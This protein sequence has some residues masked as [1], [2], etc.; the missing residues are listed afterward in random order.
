MNTFD[1]PPLE[2]SLTAAL[3]HKINHKTKPLGALGKLESLAVQIGQVQHTLT[4]QLIKPTLLIFAGDHGIA[5][6][7]VSPYPQAVTAQ[8]V[9]NFLQGGAAIN[10]FAKQQHIAL[11]IIDAGVNHCFAAH[12]QLVNA[13]IAMGTANSLHQSAMSLNQCEQALTLGA[14]LAIKEIDAGCNIIGFGEME[15]GR[16]HV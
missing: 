7:G 9:T 15:I 4:P 1:I 11:R 10:V 8:M 5:E 12:A 2:S 6:S 16:A 13:K 14:T 3:I